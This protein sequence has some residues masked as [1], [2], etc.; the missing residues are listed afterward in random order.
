MAKPK[1]TR[2][3]VTSDG[4]TAIRK[5]GTTLTSPLPF[6]AGNNKGEYDCSLLKIPPQSGLGSPAP[7][8]SRT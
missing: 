6:D 3:A 4:L 7:Q 5:L 8:A 2:D 1:F